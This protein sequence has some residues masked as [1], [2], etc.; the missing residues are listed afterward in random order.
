MVNLGHKKKLNEELLLSVKIIKC[1]MCKKEFEPTKNDIS[2]KNPNVYYKSC[3][4]CRE[5]SRE[6]TSKREKKKYVRIF[7]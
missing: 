2:T 6:Y 5:M 4:P 3:S 7:K 1:R